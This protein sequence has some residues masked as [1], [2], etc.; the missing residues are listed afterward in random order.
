MTSFFD[1]SVLLRRKHLTISSLT[2]YCTDRLRDFFFSHPPGSDEETPEALINVFISLQLLG[3]FG[4]ILVFFTV[5]FSSIAQRHITWY[6][7]ILSWIIFTTSYS[8][9]FF[10]GQL[11]DAVP[12]LQVC[13][14]QAALIYAAPPL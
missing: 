6:N 3:L 14:A 11:K 2:L 5:V 10:S 8:L 7:F 13:V 1:D 9:L 12:D 4:G